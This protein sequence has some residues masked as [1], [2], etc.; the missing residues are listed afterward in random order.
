MDINECA[1]TNPPPCGTDADCTN[2]PG[3][4]TCTCKEG[5]SGDGTTCTP[6]CGD[7]IKGATEACDDGN[8]A[9]GDG[10]SKNCTVEPGYMCQ[11]QGPGSCVDIDEC[12]TGTD[13]CLDTETCTNTMGSF[14]CTCKVPDNKVCNGTCIDITGDLFNCGDCGKICLPGQVCTAGVC[15]P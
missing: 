8:F 11:S 9:P 13:T 15:G 4:F 3:S 2:T 14:T 7:G 12:M 1:Q 5:F 6:G 10:C